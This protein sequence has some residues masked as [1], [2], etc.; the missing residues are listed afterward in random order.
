MTLSLNQLAVTVEEADAYAEARGY[1]SWFSEGT[2]DNKAALWRGQDYIAGR[3][4]GRWQV[5][6]T[7]T[8]DLVK[9]AIIEAAIRE[10]SAP[11]SLSPDYNPSALVKREKVGPL[12]TEY[13]TPTN[14]NAAQP[15]FGIIDRL[16]AGLVSSGSGATNF[17]VTRA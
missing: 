7:E 2:M 12:E 17:R 10:A 15:V 4:N 1:A 5:E 3:F 9:Y 6:W 13:A 8:P 14:A 11:G 16:L